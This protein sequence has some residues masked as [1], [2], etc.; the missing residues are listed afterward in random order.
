MTLE[1]AVARQMPAMASAAALLFWA[2]I[3]ANMG[4]A[5]FQT[6]RWLT[7]PHAP[8]VIA[9]LLIGLGIL[10]GLFFGSRTIVRIACVLSGSFFVML[11]VN[12][13]AA[14]PTAP[15][16]GFCVVFLLL[17]SW[18]A[19]FPGLPADERLTNLAR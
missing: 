11:A 10:V 9:A 13:Q 12:I 2:S 1:I 17:S 5:R 15:S 19:I 14:V 16:W 4:N 8:L 18:A 6:Y 3:T 7:V